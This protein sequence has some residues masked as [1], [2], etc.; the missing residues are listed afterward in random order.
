VFDGQPANSSNVP[1][2]AS[3]AQRVVVRF[4]EVLLSLGCLDS[5]FVRGNAPGKPGG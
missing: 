2:R 4:M 1:M 5:G 3:E